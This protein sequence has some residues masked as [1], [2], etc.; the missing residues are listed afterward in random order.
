M[1]DKK[2]RL[3]LPFYVVPAIQIR[4][5]LPDEFKDKIKEYFIGIFILLIQK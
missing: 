4:T 1:E 3:T 2:G 5:F